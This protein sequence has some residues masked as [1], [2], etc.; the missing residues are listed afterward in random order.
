MKMIKLAVIIAAFAVVM[1]CASNA[2]SKPV[3]ASS[4]VNTGSRTAKGAGSDELDHAIREISDYLN[5]RIPNGTKA[6]F[7]NVKS[8]WPALSEYILDGL[9]ENAVNDEVFA[10]VDRQQLDA[11]RSELNFQ[12]SGEVSDASAQEIGQMLGAQ[13]IVSG[14]VSTIGSIYRIQA[15][16]IAVQTA[17]VQGQFSQNVSNKDQ[18]LAALTTQKAPAPAAGRTGTG[19]QTAQAPAAGGTAR[20]TPAAPAAASYKIGDKG[21]AGGLIFYDKGNN[22]GGW[23]YLEAAPEEAEF[24]A[25]WSESSFF[26]GDD[27]NFLRTEIGYGKQNTQ[28]IIEK[29]REKTGN[30]NTAA[31]KAHDL[32]FNGFNDWFLPSQT[33]LDQMFGNLKRKDLGNFKNEKYWCSNQYNQW[34]WGNRDA[35]SQDFKDGK[36][37]G[38]NKTTVLYVRPIRQVAGTG[39]TA[40]SSAAPAS[41]TTGTTGS[42]GTSGAAGAVEV[43]KGVGRI[44]ELFGELKK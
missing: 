5:K 41:R 38:P 34:G 25:V 39:G 23:R 11:I 17:A 4:G 30:W 6:V 13:T 42:S 9:T 18:T 31:Q 27:T 10:V 7:L 22:N 20:T 37:E 15:R 28:L 19:T 14:S 29:F 3:P 44:L 35:V 8:D 43:I 1:G 2:S 21:P 24:R 26:I 12:W 40:Q 16:A 36:V 33:E 32:S